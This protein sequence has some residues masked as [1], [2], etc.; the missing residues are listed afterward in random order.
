MKKLFFILLLIASLAGACKKY[1]EGPW[2]SLRSA[3]N[4]LYGAYTLTQYTVNGT[5]SL[6]LYNDSLGLIF[7]FMYDDVNSIKLCIIDRSRK[8]GGWAT[9]NWKWRFKNKNK[10]IDIESAGGST[11][12]TGPF[13]INKLPEWEILRLTNKEIKMKTNYNYKE[14]LIKLETLVK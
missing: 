8:D 5:D 6:S 3:E 2:L 13:G 4:R 10:V 1:D 12:G 11:N 9:L 14:Y 7:W